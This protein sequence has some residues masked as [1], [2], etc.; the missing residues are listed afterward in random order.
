MWAT[1]SASNLCCDWLF[2][3]NPPSKPNKKTIKQRFLKLLPCCRSSSSSSVNQSKCQ[4]TRVH[5]H[6]E[7]SSHEFSHGENETL[8]VSLTFPLLYFRHCFSGKGFSCL[9]ES[10]GVTIS[11]LSPSLHAGSISD[12][13]E[14]TTVC[15]RPEGLDRLVQ[16]TNFSKKELQVLYRGFKNVSQRL[17]WMFHLCTFFSTLEWP[18]KWIWSASTQCGCLN[19]LYAWESMCVFLIDISL[20]FFIPTGVS[21]WCGEWRDF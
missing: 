3:G 7:S 15:Y 8:I 17:L 2:P 21:Q 6:S 1:L 11:F 4:D 5:H 16:Q 18:C 10:Q 12:D 13:A 20:C 14:L 9:R 19:Y